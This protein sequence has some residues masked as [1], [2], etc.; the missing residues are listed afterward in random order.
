MVGKLG[1]PAGLPGMGWAAEGDAVLLVGPF[2][3][4]LAG[5]ELEKQRGGLADGLPEADLALQAR[6]LAAVRALVADGLVASIHDIS[7]GGLAAALAECSIASGLG[8]RIDAGELLERSGGDADAALFGEGPGGWVVSVPAEGV[9]R[10]REAAASA[11]VLEL[12]EVT[13]NRVVAAASAASLDVQVSEL[14]N[15]YE[16]GVADRL[17]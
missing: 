16:L 7:D 11:G 17:R 14:R 5:S 15:A 1:D 6:A 8:A 2:A 4:S 10:V 12:G 3:P 9:A 13:G